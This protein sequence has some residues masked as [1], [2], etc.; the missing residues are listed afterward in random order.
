ME[1]RT[2]HKKKG[3]KKY[4]FL[5][6]VILIIGIYLLKNGS[7]E[8]LIIYVDINNKDD[9]LAEVEI[10]EDEE[11]ST[12]VTTTYDT[13]DILLNPGKGMVYY[14]KTND[15]SY[16]E[17][18]SIGYYRF[19]W[20]DIEPE[21]GE[22]NWSVIDKAIESFASSGKKFAFG[23][24]CASSVSTSPQYITPKWVFDAGAE[25]ITSEVTFWQT[26]ETST[27]TIPVWTDE[28]FL[29]KLH[30]FIEALRRKI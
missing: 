19:N 3:I 9:Y 2:S 29:E 24:K 6:I 11:T 30:D 17:I 27:Q 10:V 8:N 12:T 5:F 16:D 20:C 21:E 13:E 18:T 1:K 25:G 22:Y 7:I 4:I 26:G 14:G 28:I 15:S 23:V